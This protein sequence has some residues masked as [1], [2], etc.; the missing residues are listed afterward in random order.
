[1]VRNSTI[2]IKPFSSCIGSLDD[3]DFWLSTG[4]GTTAAKS[5]SPTAASAAA[6]A[7]ADAGKKKSKSGKGKKG[8]SSVSPAPA[9]TPVVSDVLEEPQGA[10]E[11]ETEGRSKKTKK[12]EKV[13]LLCIVRTYL[14]WVKVHIF[15]TF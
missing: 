6:P 9:V 8:T 10:E 12:G 7:S 5:P 1:M 4:T 11:E 14:V 13:S 15:G 2:S 3:L